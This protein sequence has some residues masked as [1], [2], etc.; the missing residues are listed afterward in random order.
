MLSHDCTSFFN[1]GLLSCPR[2]V[3]LDVSY[4]GLLNYIGGD[5]E[6]ELRP[7]LRWG[8]REHEEV[9]EERVWMGRLLGR[10]GKGF[11]GKSDQKRKRIEEGKSLEKGG[12]GAGGGAVAS[13]GGRQPTTTV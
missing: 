6:G 13:G 8:V 11:R 12:S 3:K 10:E 9:G 4:R 1:E 5:I 2:Q 7:R